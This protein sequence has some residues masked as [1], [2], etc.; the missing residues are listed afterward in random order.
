MEQQN[1]FAS[2]IHDQVVRQLSMTARQQELVVERAVQRAVVR[3]WGT[4]CLLLLIIILAGVALFGCAA[5]AA[6]HLLP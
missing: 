2:Q 4:R 6:I 3:R 5:L 1:R